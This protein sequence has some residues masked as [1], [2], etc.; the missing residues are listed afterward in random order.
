M[1]Y[2]NSAFPHVT[3]SAKNY[4]GVRDSEAGVASGGEM[5]GQGGA[6]R[7]VVVYITG[8]DFGGGTSFNTELII[9][10]GAI[11]ESATF[12]VSEAFT[13]G[14]ADNVF[15]IGTDGSELTNGVAI[16]NPDVASTTQDTSGAGT[17]AAALAANTAVGVSVTGTTAGVTAGSGRAK[18]VIS[19]TKI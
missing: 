10:A 13:V 12:E 11:V 6:E 7:D 9:P 17:W 14:N 5:H 16:A 1:G 18:V 8:D 2:E 3:G 15:N 19:Y 4:Y